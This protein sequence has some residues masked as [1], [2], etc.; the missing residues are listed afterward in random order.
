V[1]IAHLCSTDFAS[2]FTAVESKRDAE[3]PLPLQSPD[4][5]PRVNPNPTEEVKPRLDPSLVF[6]K[7]DAASA[8]T[9]A[10]PG[11][12]RSATLEDISLRNPSDLGARIKLA[13]ESHH[14]R[15]M[16]RCS[17]GCTGN[18][19]RKIWCGQCRSED[20][21]IGVECCFARAWICGSVE[22]VC[23]MAKKRQSARK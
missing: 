3:A 19:G 4:K 12:P 10:L 13:P 8:R 14:G 17:K 18:A 16:R 11:N 2:I 22:L 23:A 21:Q 9:L 20:V 15:L 7:R 6:R 5:P 1:M